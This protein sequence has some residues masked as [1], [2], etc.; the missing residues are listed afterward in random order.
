MRVDAG[1]DEASL[2][3]M[4]E[5]T[6]GKYFR[7]GD[8]ETLENIYEQINQLEKSKIES[9]QFDNFNDLLHWFVV[10]GLCLLL[11]ELGLRSTRFILVP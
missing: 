5:T 7:A 1:L 10:P 3:K 8:A 2:T 11:L 4:A 6:G 9:T